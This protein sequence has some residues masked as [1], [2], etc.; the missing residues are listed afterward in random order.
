MCLRDGGGDG[1]PHRSRGDAGEQA[2]WSFA[3]EAE[4][5]GRDAVI[6]IPLSRNVT[7]P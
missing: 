4:R 2:R 3:I 5:T 1:E 7:A 6:A